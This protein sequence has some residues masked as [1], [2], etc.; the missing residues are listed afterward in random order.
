MACYDDYYNTHRQS[1]DNN[2]YQRRSH[3]CRATN[4]DCLVPH[5]NELL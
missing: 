5:P 3:R 1:K 2:Y 4:Y